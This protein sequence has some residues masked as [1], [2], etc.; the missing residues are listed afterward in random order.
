[1]TRIVSPPLDDGNLAFTVG[2]VK[3]NSVQRAVLHDG[4]AVHLPENDS[5][6]NR[7]QAYCM[8][9]R[10]ENRLVTSARP[11]PGVRTYRMTSDGL[12]RPVDPEPDGKAKKRETKSKSNKPK[13]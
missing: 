8:A 3:L 9:D 7:R 12:I 10:F 6:E 4:H 11:F 13:I 1:M 2:R 5:P